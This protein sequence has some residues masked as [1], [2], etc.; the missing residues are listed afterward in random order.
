MDVLSSVLAEWLSINRDNND[1]GTAGRGISSGVNRDEFALPVYWYQFEGKNAKIRSPSID[2]ELVA[3]C[4]TKKE[5]TNMKKQQASRTL[6]S[7]D[8][9]ITIS[10]FARDL[11]NT[12]SCSQSLNV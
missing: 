5:E 11:A 2:F 3:T 9:C 6:V 4:G 1:G 10:M 8:A 12:T 7:A